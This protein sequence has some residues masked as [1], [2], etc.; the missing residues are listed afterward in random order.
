[1]PHRITSATF[2]SPFAARYP[3]GGITSSLGGGKFDDSTAMSTMIPGYPR[4]RNRSSSHWMNDS[5]IDAV[6]PDQ[7]DESRTAHVGMANAV[8]RPLDQGQH[9]RARAADR[10]QHPAPGG[11]LRHQ[12]GRHFRPPRRDHDRVVGRVRAPTED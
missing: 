10:D 12:R 11:E 1:M 8:R 6:L 5:S 7:R 3:A 2:I 9:L 4:S